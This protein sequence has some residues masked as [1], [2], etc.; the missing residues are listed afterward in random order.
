MKNASEFYS[1]LARA[2]QWLEQVNDEYRSQ[3]VKEF[4]DLVKMLPSGSGFDN[5][6]SVNLDKSTGEKII[7][8]TSFHHMD[9]HGYYDGWTYHNVII[10]PSLQWGFNIRVTGRN[11]N[12]IKDYIQHEFNSLNRLN[13]SG[14][15]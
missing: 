5:G 8:E 14:G 6:S 1:A 10:T 11:K 15:K 12:D 13:L 4:D 7:I 2:I 9:E 3:A